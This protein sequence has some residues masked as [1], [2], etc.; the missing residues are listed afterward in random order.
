MPPL[1]TLLQ[2]AVVNVGNRCNIPVAEGELFRRL[3]LSVA[4]EDVVDERLL[5][6]PAALYPVHPPPGATEPAEVPPTAVV[7]VNVDDLFTVRSV[8]PAVSTNINHI[9]S[10]H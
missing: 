6:A 1:D 7:M 10:V 9:L 4:V 8:G 5:N 3:L 2:D